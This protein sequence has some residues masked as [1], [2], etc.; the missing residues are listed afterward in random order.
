[1]TEYE[2]VIEKFKKQNVNVE[3]KYLLINNKFNG[4][5]VDPVFSKNMRAVCFPV[6]SEEKSNF[7]DEPVYEPKCFFIEEMYSCWIKYGSLSVNSE[8]FVLSD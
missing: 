6:L 5:T 7:F 3:G 2:Q 8:V 4:E 1:M